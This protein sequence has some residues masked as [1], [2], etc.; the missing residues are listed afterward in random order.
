MRACGLRESVPQ[1]LV[2]REKGGLVHRTVDWLEGKL[3][4]SGSTPF[5]SRTWGVAREARAWGWGALEWTGRIGR[6][7]I[8]KWEVFQ[9]L[10][11]TQ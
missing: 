8:G 4:K 10:L 2:T 1:T 6:I 5:L 9:N 7:Q 3:T 11:L